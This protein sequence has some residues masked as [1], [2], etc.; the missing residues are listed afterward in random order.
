MAAPLPYFYR[1]LHR[2]ILLA[3]QCGFAQ[4]RCEDDGV[5]F[6]KV[7]AL[8]CL[9]AT[10]EDGRCIAPEGERAAFAR[11]LKRARLSRR[12]TRA[13]HFYRAYLYT[14]ATLARKTR[15]VEMEEPRCC[16]PGGGMRHPDDWDEDGDW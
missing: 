6:A 11:M 5:V 14:S 12:Q 9:T 15:L 10:T 2:Y 16:D 4:Q 7:I 3:V 1:E 8:A 13:A